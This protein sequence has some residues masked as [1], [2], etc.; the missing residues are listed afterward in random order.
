MNLSTRYLLPLFV[1]FFACSI[2]IFLLGNFLDAHNIDRA[3][4]LFANA[5]FFLLSI[6]SFFIQL[7][8]MQNKNPHVFVRSVTGAMMF[9]M[10]VCIIAV[11]FYVYLSGNSFNKRGIFI[12]LFLYLVYLATEV[13]VIMKMNKHKK[14]DV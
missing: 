8:G 9:K 14:K 13:Y 3:I 6:I 11:I 2:S 5:I 4:L 1:L 12:S 10:I 7:K